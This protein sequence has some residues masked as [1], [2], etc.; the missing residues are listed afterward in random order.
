MKMKCVCL[1]LFVSGV[2][3]WCNAASATLV[4]QYLF[5]EG[6]GGVANDTG[7]APFENGTL[8]GTTGIPAWTTGLYPSSTGALR[9]NMDGDTAAQTNGQRVQL[10]D[11]SN[12]I[13][14]APGATLMA[15]V[16][17]EGG[18]N[19]RTIISINNSAAPANSRAMLQI[20]GA[21]GVNG[22]FR[23]AGRIG[24]GGSLFNATSTLATI[25]E[26][27]F[28]AGVLDYVN[29]KI[30]LYINGEPA[31]SEVTVASWAGNSADTTNTT[32]AIGAIATGSGEY[33]VGVI[34]GARI[35][36]EALDAQ[37]IKNIYIAEVPEPSA[38][39]MIAISTSAMGLVAAVRRRCR[40]H[41]VGN[42]AI[43]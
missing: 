21:S 26:T 15:W 34:D 20:T 22:Q 38:I 32:A 31:G 24:D 17:L 27:Y 28:V 23:V 16:K 14:N 37:T 36:N 11:N 42:G 10:P 35:Y 6:T 29:G 1:G 12:L 3:G 19:A 43:A 7:A 40:G 2:I 13:R 25:G 30:R 9:F 41:C 8:S 33:W 18:S 5:E 39:V 4:G